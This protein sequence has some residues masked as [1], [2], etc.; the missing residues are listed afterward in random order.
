MIF[1]V[2]QWCHGICNTALE[3]C[4]HKYCINIKKK[5]PFTFEKV[6][7]RAGAAAQ[8]RGL[9]TFADDTIV[10]SRNIMEEMF[11]AT[12]SDAKS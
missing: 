4:K 11:S 12:Q 1:L 5:I 6:E 9:I 3:Q 10:S 2:G 8:S 7:M